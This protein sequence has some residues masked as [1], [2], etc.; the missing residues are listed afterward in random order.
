MQWTKG[1]QQLKEV[2]CLL[3]AKCLAPFSSQG[4]TEY[5]SQDYLLVTENPIPRLW[6]LLSYHHYKCYSHERG[7][8][9][10]KPLVL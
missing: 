4:Y 9:P 10:S 2:Y 1:L 8:T 5:C 3:R 7:M 6:A